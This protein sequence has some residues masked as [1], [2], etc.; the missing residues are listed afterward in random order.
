MR[1]VNRSAQEPIDRQSNLIHMYFQHEM[2]AIEQGD[3]LGTVL[4]K[5]IL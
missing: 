5:T 4:F 3:R 2:A 1:S